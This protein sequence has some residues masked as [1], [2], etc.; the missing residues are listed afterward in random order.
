MPASWR[1]AFAC[2]PLDGSSRNPNT[3]SVRRNRKLAF[4]EIRAGHGQVEPEPAKGEINMKRLAQCLLAASV[5]TGTAALAQGELNYTAADI[6]K[7]PAGKYAGEVAGV[8]TNA[9]G[10]IFVYQRSGNPYRLAGRQPHLRPWPGPAAGIRR[11]RQVCARDRRR[12]LF[13]PGRQFGAG[14]RQEQC[15]GGRPLQRHGG[16]IF[17]RRFAATDAAG[18]QA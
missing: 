11:Q 6:I 17:A 8:A 18:P 5:L 10:H 3:I 16:R 13:Q 12:H 9:A 15:L 2:R 1:R 4:A 14:G 7:Y